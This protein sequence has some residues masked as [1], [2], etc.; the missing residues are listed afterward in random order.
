M[1]LFIELQLQYVG[2]A[3]R[4][5][6]KAQEVLKHSKLIGSQKKGKRELLALFNADFDEFCN[7]VSAAEEVAQVAIQV[8]SC[9]LPPEN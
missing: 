4:L 5:H 7:F 8:R 6:N 9:Q 1:K 3:I 2:E